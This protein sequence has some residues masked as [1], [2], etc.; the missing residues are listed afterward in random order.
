M[1]T[2][3]EMPGDSAS[4]AQVRDDLLAQM[5]SLQLSTTGE[6]G[7]PHCGYTP[8]L[9]CAPNA[10][11]VFVSQL[12]AHTRDMLATE[13]AAIMIIQDEAASKQ[14]FARTRV[15]Y[16]CAAKVVANDQREYTLILDKFEARH[17]KMVN[18]L[19]QLPDFTLIRLHPHSGQFVMGFGQAYKLEGENLEKFVHT[20]T[21]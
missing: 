11:Y 4:P 1:T 13:M 18:L 10:F 2:E 19:R 17:G 7:K 9:Y 8:F 21:G 14:L 20:R 3:D 16:Q 5:R 12:S 15:S 6:D